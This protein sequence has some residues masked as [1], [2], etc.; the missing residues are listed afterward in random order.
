MHLFLRAVGFSK[1]KDRKELSALITACIQDA[2]RRGY[3]TTSGDGMLAEF[4]RDFADD[5]GI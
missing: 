4:A 2:T 1:I 3:V 5:I